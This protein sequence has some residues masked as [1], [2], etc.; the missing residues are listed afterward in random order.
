MVAAET[1]QEFSKS[2]H[3]TP[4]DRYLAISTALKNRAARWARKQ[5]VGDGLER[6]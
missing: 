3:A 6:R 1:A 5:L 2:R 4:S